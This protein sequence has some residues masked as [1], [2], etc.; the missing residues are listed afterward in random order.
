MTAQQRMTVGLLLQGLTVR[1]ACTA[2][3]PLHNP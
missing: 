2:T 3:V 1:V